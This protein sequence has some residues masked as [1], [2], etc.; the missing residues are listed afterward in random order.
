MSAEDLVYRK[1][2]KEANEL[3]NTLLAELMIEGVVESKR[4][5]KVGSALKFLTEAVKIYES[6][7]SN[8]L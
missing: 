1:Q 5:N 3:G 4:N 2:I 7:I 8:L 6:E